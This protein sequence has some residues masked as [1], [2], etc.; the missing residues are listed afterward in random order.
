VQNAAA[1]G[2]AGGD[3]HLHF[4]G[5][6]DGPAIERFLTPMIRRQIP[7]AVSGAFR[8]NALTDRTF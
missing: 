1:Q 6:A 5:P 3:T 4:H 7:G 8:S 2:S